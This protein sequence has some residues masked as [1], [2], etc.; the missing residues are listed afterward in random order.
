MQEISLLLMFTPDEAKKS[1][2]NMEFDDPV[3]SPLL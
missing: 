2:A 3:P 1:F